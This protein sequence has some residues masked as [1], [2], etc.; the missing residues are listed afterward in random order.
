MTR[1]THMAPA[2][3]APRKSTKLAA[4]R[5]EATPDGEEQRIGQMLSYRRAHDSA[6]EAEFIAQFILP[7]RPDPIVDGTEVHALVVS[8]SNADGSKPN[9]AFCA[10]TDS[11]HNRQ[12]ADVRQTIGFDGVRREFF[13]NNLKQRDCLGADDAAGCYVL[14]RMIEAGVPGLY[15]FFRGEERGGIGS[16]YIVDNRPELFD[17]IEYAIQFDR[18]GTNSIITEMMCGMTCSDGF[19]EA[20]AD[21]LGMGHKVDPTGSFTDTANLSEIVAECTN[22]SVGYENEHSS[23][24]T[25]STG[26]LLALVDACIDAFSDSGLALPVI[27]APGEYRNAIEFIPEFGKKYGQRL[28]TLEPVLSAF[29]LPGMTLGQL[30]TAICSMH[31]DD[32][33]ELLYEAGEAIGEAYGI[34]Y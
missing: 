23:S 6:G 4:K 19:A 13:V 1:E 30:R 3:T 29:D 24:E 17:E 26:Y 28:S 16:S 11:V 20:L 7:L 10:H 12:I 31:D 2:I 33:A 14:I 34:V 27:R 22:V 32:I 21:A 8:I 5:K 18:R 9:R 25:L 15:V